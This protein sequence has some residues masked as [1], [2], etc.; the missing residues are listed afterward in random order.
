M[1]YELCR[2]WFLNSLIERKIYT[3]NNKDLYKV[4]ARILNDFNK[5]MNEITENDKS[6]NF[7]EYYKETPFNDDTVK[8]KSS[9]LKYTAKYI[10][11]LLRL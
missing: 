4:R 9:T 11:D 5:Y 8:I 7:I 2:L 6:F 1:K 10:K 3:K